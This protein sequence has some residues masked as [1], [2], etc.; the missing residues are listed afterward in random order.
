VN[1]KHSTKTTIANSHCTLKE[2]LRMSCSLELIEARF[3]IGFT[4]KRISAG[5]ITVY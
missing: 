3:L 1:T 5:T 4:Q 2:A